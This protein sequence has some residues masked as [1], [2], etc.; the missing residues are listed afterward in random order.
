ML[1]PGGCWDRAIGSLSLTRRGVG[2]A[3]VP[4]HLQPGTAVTLRRLNP[5]LDDPQCP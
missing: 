2:S 5:R 3:V 1:G 4:L